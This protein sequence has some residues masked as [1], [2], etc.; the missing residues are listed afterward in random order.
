MSLSRLP[1]LLV[2]SWLLLLIFLDLGG[3]FVLLIC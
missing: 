3:Y 1:G 2:V